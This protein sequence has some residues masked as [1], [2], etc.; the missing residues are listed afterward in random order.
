MSFK[1]FKKTVASKDS[2][3]ASKT[4]AEI[5]NKKKTAKLGKLVKASHD[6]FESNKKSLELFSKRAT[7]IEGILSDKKSAKYTIENLKNIS[8]KIAT[9]LKEINNAIKIASDKIDVSLICQVKSASF[10]EKGNSVSK[11]LVSGLSEQFEELNAAKVAFILLSK[12]VAAEVDELGNDIS[13][14]QFLEVDEN[15]YIEEP[16]TPVDQLDEFNQT[17]AEEGEEDKTAEG[18]SEE[19]E[20]NMTAEECGDSEEDKEA[21]DQLDDTFAA[22]DGEDSEEDDSEE[23]PEEDKD[24]KKKKKSDDLPQEDFQAEGEDD[25]DPELDDDSVLDGLEDFGDEPTGDDLDETDISDED[26]DQEFTSVKSA[27]AVKTNMKRAANVKKF[28][29]SESAKSNQREDNAVMKF[30][31]S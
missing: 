12:K 24:A 19:D 11:K 22:E 6:S 21:M 16:A 18:E 9:T 8:S 2:G 25:M 20:S 4:A 31:M 5:L 27:S 10:N 1:T 23:K 14:D 26:L 17:F 30:L 3:A 15:G 28:C 7:L 13:D 29:S